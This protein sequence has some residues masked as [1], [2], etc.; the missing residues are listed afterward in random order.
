MNRYKLTTKIIM[1]REDDI[2][3]NS[4]L[5]KFEIEDIIDEITEDNRNWSLLEFIGE[6]D[7]AIGT[8]VEI[9]KVGRVKVDDFDIEDL[10]GVWQ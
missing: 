3:I 5:S 1:S 4:D 10:K 6:L 8:K 2:I 9:A 7:K